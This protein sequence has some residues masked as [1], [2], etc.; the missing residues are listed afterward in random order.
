[1]SVG[2]TA[3]AI[4]A[5]FEEGTDLTALLVLR[6]HEAACLIGLNQILFEL[7][8]QPKVDFMM[9]SK[10]DVQIQRELGHL[11]LGVQCKW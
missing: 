4:A 11:R 3:V 1:M 5:S 8:L 9:H 2:T 10:H 6:R 7:E